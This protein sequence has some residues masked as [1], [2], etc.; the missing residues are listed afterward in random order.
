MEASAT[1]MRL[2]Q[3]TASSYSA[4]RSEHRARR[5]LEIFAAVPDGNVSQPLG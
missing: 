2:P 1:D 5:A 4:A 3:Y